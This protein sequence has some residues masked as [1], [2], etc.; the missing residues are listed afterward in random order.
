MKLFVS[1]ASDS[2][3]CAAVRTL[4]SEGRIGRIAF[5]SC[6]MVTFG[7]AATAISSSRPRFSK[8]ACAVGRS[9]PASVAPPIVRPELNCMIPEIRNV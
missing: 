8:R 6:C 4:A 2:T 1:A 7:F 3:C 9:K 5:T